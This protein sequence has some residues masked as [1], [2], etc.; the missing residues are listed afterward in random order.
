MKF[1]PVSSAGIRA[2]LFVGL[3]SVPARADT[4]PARVVTIRVPKGTMQPQAVADDSGVVH[5]VTLRGEAD[6][7]SVV[8]SRLDPGSDSFGP[9][10]VV[11]GKE[12]CAT[13]IG[14]IRGAQIAVGGS[15]RVQVLWNG[16]EAG[17]LRNPFGGS[18]LLHSRSN[19]EG[20]EFDT[21]R[22]LMTRTSALDGGGTIAA[23][24][25]GNVYA[26][27]QASSE[28][29]PAGE[30][31]RRLWIARSSNDGAT[32]A[33]ERPAIDE[34]I[35]ACACCGVKALT[36]QEGSL[37]ILYRDAETSQDRNLVLISSTDRGEHFRKDL[38]SPWRVA[39][40]PVSRAAMTTTPRGFLA[41][42][43][44][45]GHVVFAPFSVGRADGIGPRRVPVGEARRKHPAIARN[46]A[47]EILIAWAEGTGWMKG[48]DL[49][50][51]LYDET[52]ARPKERGR[53]DGGIPTWGIPAVVARKDRSFLILH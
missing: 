1:P 11:A 48:G 31:G 46:E 19:V 26:I 42:W 32:F 36:D 44:V 41:A 33:A 25:R 18:P 39:S 23:D 52:G 15:G 50:W 35:G 9:E 51:E 17:K 4:P 22:N 6:A 29:A 43:E 28:D 8:Y 2:V 7:A 24:P 34:E 30:I 47:G 10:V 16:S 37:A 21:P 38:V 27:W 40:C 13:A 12:A 53:L 5:L 49:V 3:L 14:S 20:T 45:E